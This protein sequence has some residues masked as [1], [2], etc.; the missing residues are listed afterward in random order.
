MV[1]VATSGKRCK[2]HGGLAPVGAANPNYKHGRNS[3]YMPA[4]LRDR[5]QEAMDDPDLLN[6]TRDLALL[7]ARITDLLQRVDFG[8]AGRHWSKAQNTFVAF[9]DAVD[10]GDSETMR[11]HLNSLE[12]ILAKGTADYA[13]WE[14]VISTIEQRRK[15][16]ETEMRR[17]E[18]MNQ[19][20]TAEQVSTLMA[21]I[22]EA[23]KRVIQ[24]PK[25]LNEFTVE[26]ATLLN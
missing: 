7:E 19:F 5:Y 17:L 16:T 21:S 25:I 18:K 23:A 3:K 11:I 8:E 26:L 24:D 4:R 6:I 1:P 10:R 20:V 15:L 9:K 14:E 2:H 12:R 22:A 13:A